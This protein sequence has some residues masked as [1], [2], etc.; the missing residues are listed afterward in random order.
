MHSSLRQWD[1][2]H[3]I[4][5]DTRWLVGAKDP[6]NEKCRLCELSLRSIVGRKP[7]VAWAIM[8]SRTASAVAATETAVGDYR[9]TILSL[10]AATLDGFFFSANRLSR[11]PVTF[12]QILI[13][14]AIFVRDFLGSDVRASKHFPPPRRSV[15]V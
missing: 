10:S 14:S 9:T 8:N 13:T 7:N 1:V 6:W 2:E 4:Y 3:A 15:H 12:S 5:F 11:T